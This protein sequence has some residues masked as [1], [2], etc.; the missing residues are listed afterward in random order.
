MSDETVV[1]QFGNSRAE[2]ERT[3]A[4]V[5][6]VSLDG[7]QLLKPTR[8][9]VDTHGGM[10]LLI[11]YANRIKNAMYAWNDR[12]Y[13]LPKNNG[14]HSIHGLTRSLKW[15]DTRKAG[16]SVTM[17]VRLSSDGYP[18]PLELKI[19]YTL[20]EKRFT[21]DV[22]AHNEGTISAPFM[23]GMHPYFMHG[24][25]WKI[26]GERS[27][28]RLNYE[29]SYFPDGSITPVNPFCINS[30]SD[31]SYD[32][33]YFVGESI[34]LKTKSHGVLLETRNMPFF[35]IYNGEYAEGKS[36][37]VEPMTGAPD[38]FNNNIGLATIPAGGH[39]SSSASFIIS[40]QIP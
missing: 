17:S 3:G 10:A 21:V 13:F 4:Y 8:D 39:F 1:L 26:D 37:A 31:I 7:I 12:E 20:T 9:G 16:N 5:R 28:L 30:A 19:S 27:L 38:A 29:D 25:Q 6:T 24:G 22:D 15:D 34:F 36:V 40:R 32:N 2:I 33:C 35:V 18:V 14:S 23:A 11:P